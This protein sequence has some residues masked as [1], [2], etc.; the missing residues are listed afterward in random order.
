M[1]QVLVL[2][3]VVSGCTGRQSGSGAKI[4]TSQDLKPDATVPV[5]ASLKIGEIDMPVEIRQKN[6]LDKV[7]L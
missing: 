4:E 7:T 3:L 1:P 5:K 6:E 2:V